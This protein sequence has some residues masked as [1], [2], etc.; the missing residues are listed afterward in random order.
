MLFGSDMTACP[1]N[2]DDLEECVL[3]LALLETPSGFAMFNISHE[4]FTHRDVC[5]HMQSPGVMWLDF[6]DPYGY[7]RF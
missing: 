5:T 7:F 1:L 2:D 3:R 4:V 6:K